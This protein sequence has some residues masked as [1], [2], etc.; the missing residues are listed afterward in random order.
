MSVVKSIKELLQTHHTATNTRELWE[1]IKTF[2]TENIY[3]R[4]LF[5]DNFY[6]LSEIISDPLTF[7]GV[8]GKEEISAVDLLND[9]EVSFLRIAGFAEKSGVIE[10]KNRH[11]KEWFKP[12]MD[13]L[14][15]YIPF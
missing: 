11:K 6:P 14:R 13:S 4:S 1:A 7:A 2:G 3:V 12:E 5:Y 10:I 9:N 8:Y 15:I